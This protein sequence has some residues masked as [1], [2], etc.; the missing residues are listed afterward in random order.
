MFCERVLDAA[1]LK[2][3]YLSHDTPLVPFIRGLWADFKYLV[4]NVCIPEGLFLPGL[5]STADEIWKVDYRYCLLHQKLSLLNICIHQSLQRSEKLVKY[6]HI[7]EHPFVKDSIEGE[8]QSPIEKTIK[9]SKKLM[10]VFT[11]TFII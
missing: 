10:N 1:S 4:K 3:K 9:M 6:T 2:S 5:E 11:G 8:L 7:L